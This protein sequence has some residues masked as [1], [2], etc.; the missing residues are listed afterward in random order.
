MREWEMILI[1][2]SVQCWPVCQE[3]E[4]VLVREVRLYRQR[5]PLSTGVHWLGVQMSPGDQVVIFSLPTLWRSSREE[6]NLQSWL[7]A[8]GSWAPGLA[9]G[10][11]WPR[12][13]NAMCGAFLCETGTGG[14]VCWWWWEEWDDGSVMRQ[15]GIGLLT[16][17][18]LTDQLSI[19]AGHCRPVLAS[20]GHWSLL[21]RAGPGCGA[22]LLYRLTGGHHT[23]HH[24]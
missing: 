11:D 21:V 4:A 6:N 22:G 8:R 14:D 24:S 5:T 10:R 23:P 16:A 13:H 12:Q 20:P 1:I 7:A 15:D 18:V 2:Q 19:G 3:T 9:T 17:R